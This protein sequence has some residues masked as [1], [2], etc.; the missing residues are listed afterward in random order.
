MR[1]RVAGYVIAAALLLTA[2]GATRVAAE[3]LER[4]RFRHYTVDDGL[5]NLTARVVLQD[6]AGFIWIGTQN[7]LNRFDGYEF[8]K[9]TGDA[10][11]PDALRDGSITALADDGD[12]G[13]WV[14]SL[15]GGLARYSARTSRFTTILARPGGLASDAITALV[16]DR[17]GMLWIGSGAGHL[18]RFDAVRNRFDQPAGMPANGLGAIRAL[19]PVRDGSMLVASSRGFWQVDARGDRSREWRD[20][21]GGSI[22]AHSMAQAANGE[23]A[24]G[25]TNA[26]VLHVDEKGLEVARSTMADG[27]ADSTVRTVLFD[28]QGRLWAG[29]NDGLSR[30][31]RRGSEPRTWRFGGQQGGL[32]SGRVQT[33]M[34]DREGI[35]WVGT[36]LNGVSLFD[37]R[38]EAIAELRTEEA[39][40]VR[41]P[42]SAVPGLLTDTDGTVWLGVLES[43]G[44]VQFDVRRGLLR[45][46][47]PQP[48]VEG[49]LPN[50]VVQHIFRDRKGRLWVATA[51]GGLAFLDRG[52]ERFG[53]LRHDPADPGSLPGDVIQRVLETRGGDLW[54][55]TIESG[56]AMRCADCTAFRRFGADTLGGNSVNAIF[57]DSAGDVWIGLRPGGLVRYRPRTGAFERWAAEP[58]N[59]RALSH[60]A[61][62][63]VMEDSKARIWLGTLGGGIVEVVMGPERIV[64]TFETFASRDGLG[65]DAIG[66]ILED[67][68]GTLWI[69][70]I[71][72]LSR[73]DPATRQVVNFG[74]SE[75]AQP[76]GYFIGAYDRLPDGRLLFG[77]LRGVT[78]LE[79]ARARKI[80]NAP[81]VVVT[82]AFAGSTAAEPGANLMTDAPGAARAAQALRL[83]TGSNDFALEV[84]ALS[85]AAPLELRYA[86]RLDGYDSD[87]IMTD[88]RRRLAMYSNLPPGQYVF[89]ARAR[90]AEGAWGPELHLPVVLPAS[91]HQTAS[92]RIG[93][94][95]GVL[96]LLMLPLWMIRQH[97]RERERAAA[98]LARSEDRLRQALHGSGD[99]LWDVD[100]MKG[101]GIERVNPIG[102]IKPS[103]ESFALTFE[104]FLTA[105]HPDDREAFSRALSEHLTG[106]TPVFEVVYRLERID[107][108]WAWLRSRGRISGRQED[109]RASRLTGMTEDITAL[110]ESE[111]ALQKL[112]EQ[113]DL[114]VRE[115]TMDLTHAND[116]LRV[117]ID[118]LRMAENQLVESEKLAALGGLVAGVAHEI[119]T[120]LGI[121]VT[122]ASHLEHETERFNRKAAAGQLD[123]AEF[124]RYRLM[125]Y[126]SSQLIL[127]NL[128]RA[129]KLVRSFKQVAV[130]Q[131]S[132]ARRRIEFSS[133]LDEILLSLKPMLKKT[134]HRV[135]RD[136]AEGI[137][138]ET[139]PGAMYQIASNLTMNSV[140]HGFEGISDGK[141]TIRARRV[142]EHAVIEYSDN[143]RGMDA[144]VRKQVFEPFF[145]TKRGAGGSGL[146]MHIVWNLVTQVLGGTI[147]CDSSPGA[148]TRFTMR[149]PLSAP[150]PAQQDATSNDV[151]P[152]S[153]R[154]GSPLPT[155]SPA[156]D[157]P[158]P[159]RT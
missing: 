151:S 87:W 47:A 49:Q 94:F 144:Q 99:E 22:N 120:P 42:G 88:P 54:V 133:Y 123:A 26:G 153:A 76:W 148:G 142:Q 118:E 84:S 112:N 77:G 127:R 116:Q 103:A 114:H 95:L 32:S 7:G 136:V 46:Y 145:T 100:L 5:S 55:G 52:S 78:V 67:R 38:T 128:R 91:W 138:M 147:D 61:V 31:D 111:I 124:E 115:R 63:V 19:A 51:G 6:R 59:P 131:A 137:W 140:Q 79:P 154:A 65:A 25:T 17:S 34:H 12:G 135:E 102:H 40:P 16:R 11:N 139:Y 50:G 10:R 129:D 35:L 132:E 9:F 37:P 113:L 105:V 83:P 8:R 1:G 74:T 62:S 80:D 72:G 44:L 13:V 93:L 21:D 98:E 149:V 60:G 158:V 28:P 110:K 81:R 24:I 70:T 96:G 159:D 56:A 152:A 101:G 146:G 143:G 2:G 29:T 33:L 36:W 121:G 150:I 41:L 141:I 89:R 68:A 92:A 27:L 104:N 43:G 117:T 3:P 14:G 126:E 48:G 119:N 125:A 15:S 157:R 69:S 71:G 58:G 18:Q 108:G 122:A 130:D 86:Y 85:Y 155:S 97:L 30:L 73:F 107:G 20:R 4:V 134:G 64:R 109:G 66:G 23:I 82:R 57:E 45:R 156:A 106:K 53:V 39:D 90:Y 75:G